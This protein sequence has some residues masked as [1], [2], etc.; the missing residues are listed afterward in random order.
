[1]G[2]YSTKSPLVYAAAIT[3]DT[4]LLCATTASR[5]LLVNTAMVTPK[6]A[7]DTQGLQVLTMN[8][9]RAVRLLWVRPYI[10]G[11]VENPHRLR[12]KAL[13]AAGALVKDGVEQGEQLT[14]GES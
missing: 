2:A 4:E 7:R 3:E 9:K 5:M 10:E 13:P 11:M 8:T 6:A 1:M 12:T 14:L